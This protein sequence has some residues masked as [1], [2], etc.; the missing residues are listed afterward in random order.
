MIRSILLSVETERAK[1][2]TNVA[3][4]EDDDDPGELEPIHIDFLEI[5]Q[6]IP[7]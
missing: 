2:G 6:L 7:I 1:T 3:L 4:L 5:E